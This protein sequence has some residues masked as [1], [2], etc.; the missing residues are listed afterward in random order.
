MALAAPFQQRC[1]HSKP[2]AFQ[3]EQVEAGNHQVPPEL[4]RL[5]CR[6][7]EKAGD[8]G[9]MLLRNYRYLARS[10]SGATPTIAFKPTPW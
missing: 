1:T 4:L 6:L 9:E 3:G 10:V 8:G 7:A 2:S 5:H